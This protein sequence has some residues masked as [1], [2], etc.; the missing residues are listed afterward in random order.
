[1]SAIASNRNHNGL[2]WGALSTIKHG[3]VSYLFGTP[4]A[5]ICHLRGWVINKQLFE[6][7]AQLAVNVRAFSEAG[8][9]E[10]GLDKDTALLLCST[11][12]LFV[13]LL[14]F[15]QAVRCLGLKVI[16]L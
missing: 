8:L 1:V 3:G 14:S 6:A 5:H 12:H 4:E 9:D 7:L 15:K 10:S 11:L 16:G 13:K 2:I